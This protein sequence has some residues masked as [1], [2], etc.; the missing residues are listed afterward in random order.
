MKT[1]DDFIKE[2]LERFDSDGPPEGHF[3][4]FETR[5]QKM[6]KPESRQIRMVI[7]RVAASV[8]LGLVLSYAALLEFRYLDRRA[9]SMY[10]SAFYPELKE[11]ESF[12]NAQLAKKYNEIQELQFGGADAEKKLIARE[13]SDMNIRV[14]DM[15]KDLRSN[16]EDERIMNAIINMYQLKIELMDMII[17]R[18]HQ[19]TIS[20]L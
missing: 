10:M 12:Y 15:K 5:L 9:D 8:L 7:L 1:I 18:A 4:R 13:L 20:I 6:E 17:A 11:A 19:S 16:P 14:R 2:N 3:E